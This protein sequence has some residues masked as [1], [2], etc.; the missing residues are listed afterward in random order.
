MRK[1]R[2]KYPQPRDVGPVMRALEIHIPVDE[3][4]IYGMRE[5][6]KHVPNFR[7]QGIT[8]GI[9]WTVDVYRGGFCH[10]QVGEQSERF[11]SIML[12]INF[13]RVYL[14]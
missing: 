2:P 7:I 9:T 11:N 1:G 13:L 6:V 12:L 10:A 14:K 5:S 3:P 4:L 8:N